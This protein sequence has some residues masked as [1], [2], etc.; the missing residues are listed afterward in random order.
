MKPTPWGGLLVQLKGWH[1][2]SSPVNPV[3]VFNVL[4]LVGRTELSLR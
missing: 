1:Q 4:P 3:S 2:V